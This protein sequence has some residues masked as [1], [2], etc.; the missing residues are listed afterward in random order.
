MIEFKTSVTV[1]LGFVGIASSSSNIAGRLTSGA[2][3]SF[4]IAGALIAIVFSDTTGASSRIS[5]GLGTTGT[6][7]KF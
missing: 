5:V 1:A 4:V 7:I 2:V 6:E 3:A